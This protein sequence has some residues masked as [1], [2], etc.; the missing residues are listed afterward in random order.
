MEGRFAA[1]WAGETNRYK[2]LAEPAAPEW[3]CPEAAAL[4]ALAE[5]TL[6]AVRESR[7]PVAIARAKV[8]LSD[9]LDEAIFSVPV[10][11][12]RHYG[13]RNGKHCLL[14]VYFAAK[15]ELRDISFTVTGPQFWDPQ[16]VV[17]ALPPPPEKDPEPAGIWFATVEDED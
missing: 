10:A 15:R 17:P 2:S 6:A 9:R 16:P 11:H 5:E 7:S 14:D 4:F 8:L 13:A 3:C 1:I 12:R